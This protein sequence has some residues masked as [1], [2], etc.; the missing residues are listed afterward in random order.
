MIPEDLWEFSRSFHYVMHSEAP[1]GFAL[2]ND[3]AIDNGGDCRNEANHS[4]EYKDGG[5]RH[6]FTRIQIL[7]QG[8]SDMRAGLW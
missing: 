1:M 8:F 3:R 4:G 5:D 7:F 6:S 2:N